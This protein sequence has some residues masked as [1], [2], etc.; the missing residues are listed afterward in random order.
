MSLTSEWIVH[1]GSG[2][3]DVSGD[4]LIKVYFRDKTFGYGRAHDWD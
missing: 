3:P 4:S 2:D 1:D